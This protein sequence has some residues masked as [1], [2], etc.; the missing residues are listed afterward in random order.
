M[1]VRQTA[2]PIAVAV[3]GIPLLAQRPA[4][5]AADYARAETFLAANVQGLV[6]GGSVTPNWLPDGRFWFRNQ[7][8]NG[9]EIVV[10]D[11][12]KKTRTGYPDCAAAGV[13][14]T[15]E[16]AAGGRGGRGGGRGGRGGGGGAAAGGA[17]AGG[18]ASH[19]PESR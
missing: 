8:L 13:D 10:V 12:V 19:R 11:P 14:C 3:L 7:T 18:G 5:T 9:A 17:G 1:R 6:V 4:V 16:A 15:N 2:L